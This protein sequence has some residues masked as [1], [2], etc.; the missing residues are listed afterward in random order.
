MTDLRK[1][2]LCHNLEVKMYH[3]IQMH[4]KKNKGKQ[5]RYI[6]FESFTNT[7]PNFCVIYPKNGSTNTII[8]IWSCCESIEAVFLQDMYLYKRKEICLKCTKVLR[9][10]KEVICPKLEMKIQNII[11]DHFQKNKGRQFRFI[12]LLSI[13]NTNQHF[14]IIYPRDDSTNSVL[15]LWKCCESLEPVFA[16]DLCLYKEKEKC[17]KCSNILK[18]IFR[19]LR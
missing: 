15:L 3:V 4:V 17:T 7:N 19:V 11:E 13:K 5:R 18:K 10:G 6:P 1:R 14:V 16:Q 12:P 2:L 8:L 9:E